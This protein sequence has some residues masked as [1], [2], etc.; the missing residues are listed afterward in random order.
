[1][2]ANIWNWCKRSATIVLARI[3][4]IG[5][6]VGAGL[7]LAFSGYDFTQLATVDWKSAFKILVSLA[8]AGVLTEIARRRTLPKA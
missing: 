5:G 2:L 7:L 6:I 8:V 3:Q 4:S 1:M